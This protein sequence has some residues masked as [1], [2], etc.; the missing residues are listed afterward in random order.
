M[1]IS[2]Q[3]TVRPFSETDPDTVRLLEEKGNGPAGKDGILFLRDGDTV[4]SCAD[5]PEGA[6]LLQAVSGKTARGAKTRSEEQVWKDAVYGTADP[7]DL[8]KYRIREDVPRCVILFRPLQDSRRRIQRD[9]IPVEETDRILEAENGDAVLILDL[10]KRSAEEAFEYAAAAAETMESEAGVSC[11]AGIGG[12]TGTVGMLRQSREEAEAA[13]ETGIRYRLPGRVYAYDRQM[14]ERLTDLIPADQA[15]EFRKK[16]IPP[17]AEKTLTN[18]ILET[19]RVFFL[20]DLNLSTTARQLFIHRNTLMY[21]ME[22]VR[23]ATGLD[24]RKFEDAV[25]FRMMMNP[26]GNK[27]AGGNKD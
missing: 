1:K 16:L 22:K 10:K 7:A 4:Y 11:M 17:Q 14:L 25:V 15:E 18:E 2:V 3:I 21:R 6:A 23:K 20:N 19:V 24:L 8:R 5:T 27:D 9:M 13:M 12:T 26:G